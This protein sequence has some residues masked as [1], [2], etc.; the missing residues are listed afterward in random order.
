[1]CVQLLQFTQGR[2]ETKEQEK[3]TQSKYY[4]KYKNDTRALWTSGRN[5]VYHLS[6]MKPLLEDTVP[7]ESLLSKSNTIMFLA[8]SL[9]MAIPAK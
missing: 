5:E 1:M 9:S 6:H 3:F 8:L 2:S 7:R 4:I